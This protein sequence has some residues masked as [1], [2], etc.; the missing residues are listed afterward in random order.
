MNKLLLIFIAVII[1]SIGL[2]FIII[3][4]NL[5]S[6]GYSFIDYIYYIF[7]HFSCNIF[8]IGIIILYITNKNRSMWSVIFV[9]LNTYT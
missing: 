7:T 4:L 3:N 9:R 5:L 1:C 2:S 8:F 6:I